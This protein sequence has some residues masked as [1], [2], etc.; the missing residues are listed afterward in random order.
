MGFVGVLLWLNVELLG[1]IQP[2]LSLALVKGFIGKGLV[3]C[4]V[5]ILHSLLASQ[6]IVF[7][8]YR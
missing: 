5:K 2:N 6:K 7:S 1:F 4:S 8:S 3:I